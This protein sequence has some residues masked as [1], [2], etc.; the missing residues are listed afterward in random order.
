[1]YSIEKE[2]AQVV[3]VLSTLEALCTIP[4][5]EMDANKYIRSI[6][7]SAQKKLSI[8]LENVIFTISNLKYEIE[9]QSFYKY[10]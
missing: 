7:V 4:V 8:Y 3:E 2:S 1:M 6:L 10:K 9:R 5:L